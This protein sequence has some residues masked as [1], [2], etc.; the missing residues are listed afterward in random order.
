VKEAIN[1]KAAEKEAKKAGKAGKK[2]N[3]PTAK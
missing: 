3:T 2:E 1:K